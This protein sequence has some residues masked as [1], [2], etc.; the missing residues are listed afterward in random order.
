[1]YSPLHLNEGTLTPPRN[2][3][4]PLGGPLLLYVSAGWNREGE[5]QGCLHVG[6]VGL[7][8]L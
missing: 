1:M 8:L 3:S 7:G 5:D 6:V 2:Y 4:V